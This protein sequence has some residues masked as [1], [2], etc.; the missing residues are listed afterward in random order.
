MERLVSCFQ[1]G[2]EFSMSPFE[3]FNCIKESHLWSGWW[4]CQD[5]TWQSEYREVHQKAA[6]LYRK[7]ARFQLITTGRISQKQLLFEDQ[8][9]ERLTKASRYFLPILLIQKN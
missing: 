2:D 1:M 4:H 7:Q 3:P 9:L 5:S 8:H 6:V